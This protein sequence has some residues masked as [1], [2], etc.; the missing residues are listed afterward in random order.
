MRV[1]RLLLAQ[2]G[3][4]SSALSCRNG[5]E[6]RF[7]R[8]RLNPDVLSPKAVQKYIPMVDTVARDFSE[9]LKKKVLQNAR[10]SLTQDVQPSIFNYIIEGV[11]QVGGWGLC[12]SAQAG[13]GPG[14]AGERQLEARPVL[15]QQCI[16]PQPAT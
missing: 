14:R 10:G 13:K 15:T 3:L 11:G 16:L 2:G 7:N 6:W 1:W 8:T 9:A 5:P 4:S 12:D